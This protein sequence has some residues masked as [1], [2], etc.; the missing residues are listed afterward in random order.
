MSKNK[1]LT[2]ILSILAIVVLLVVLSSTVFAVSR[3]EVV[4]Q[5]KTN[6]MQSRTENEIITNSG[7]TTGTN[8]FLVN[9]EEAADKL[10][11]HYPYIKV[12]GIETAFPNLLKIHA[13]EREALFA[14]YSGSSILLVDSEFKVIEKSSSFVSTRT[15]AI[16]VT[17]EMN[18][19]A[20]TV[21]DFLTPTGLL[22]SFKT[23]QDS[24]Y[25]NSTEDITYDVPAMQAF[26]R[27][28]A[29]TETKMVFETYLGV[30]VE[31]GLPQLDQQRKI[32]MLYEVLATLSTS[33]RAGGTIHVWTDTV[34]GKIKGSYRPDE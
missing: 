10:E 8:V 11:K 28:I 4:W 23:L 13:I 17:G 9:K 26:I 12:L 20:A 22:A 21:G 29:F 16:E 1:T 24:F 2:I 6:H 7:L 30:M 5:S 31:I 3:I 18:F 33:E 34:S 27:S 32:A 15:N 25:V 14:L 19:A